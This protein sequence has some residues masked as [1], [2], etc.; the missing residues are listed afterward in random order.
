TDTIY[1]ATGNG[2]YDPTNYFWGQSVL[3][4]HVDGTGV[5][6]GPIDSYTPTN[7]QQLSLNDEDLG[8]MAPARIPVPTASRVPHLAMQAGKDGMLRLLNLDNLSGQGI[9]GQTGARSG[10]CRYRRGQRRWGRWPC[11]APRRSG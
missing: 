4:L 10:F 3:A 2:A 6:A 11:G 7:F 1:V 8:G 5:N 9:P